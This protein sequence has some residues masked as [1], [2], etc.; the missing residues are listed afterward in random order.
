MTS[1]LRIPTAYAP[2]PSVGDNGSEP[3]LISRARSPESTTRV[4]ENLCRNA[5]PA[6]EDSAFRVS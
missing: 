4:S 6:N 5:R 1:G 3:G 2:A